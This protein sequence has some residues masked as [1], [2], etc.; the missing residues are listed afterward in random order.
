MFTPVS[1]FAPTAD[2][3][4]MDALVGR[5]GNLFWD[6]EFFP[7]QNAPLDLALFYPGGLA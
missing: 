2:V 1:A 3:Q 4:W 5:N 6:G 7:G